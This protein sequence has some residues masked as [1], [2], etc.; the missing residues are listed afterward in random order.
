MPQTLNLSISGM[1]CD[2]CA[3]NVD[4]VLR[5]LP[6]VTDSSTDWRGSSARVIGDGF[7]GVDDVRAAVAGLGFAVTAHRVE[8]GSSDDGADVRHL[9]IIGSGAAAMAAAL[10]AAEAGV[11][12]TLIER[13]RIGGTCVNVGCVP[14]KTLIRAA[15]ALHRA[16]STPFAG[17]EVQGRLRDPAAL[18]R[19]RQDLVDALQQQK[20]VDV[21]ADHPNIRVL[22]GSARFTDARSVRVADTMVRFDRCLIATGSRPALPDIPGLREAQPLDSTAALELESLP[23]SLVILGGRIVALELAQAFARLGVAVTIIQRSGRI[24]PEVDADAAEALTGFLRN[25]GITILTGTR[26]ERVS[27]GPGATSVHLATANGAQVVSGERLL[28]ALGRNA[29]TGDL[30][31]E[32]AGIALAADGS[33]T[34][35]DHLRT[36]NPAVFAAGDVIGDPAFVYAA[37]YEGRVAATNALGGSITRDEAVL[38]WVLFTDPQIA[39]V[40]LGED[41]ARARGI[42]VAVSRLPLDQVP[43]ALAARDTRGFLKLIKEADGDRL[44]GAVFVAPE[45]GDLIQEPTLAIRHGITVPQIIDTFHP[46]LTQIEGVRLAAQG[47]T[48][49]PAKRSC[50]A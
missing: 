18:A 35:D 1:T 33:V 23:L 50:C 45:A 41:A 38:P 12:V 24:L 43:R 28:V 5:T 40:G 46:Y 22:H 19:Q 47:F 20:Y 25:E 11:Q 16:Q 17:L 2:Q 49:D 26:I 30:D 13:G 15:E 7:L 39:V 31:P 8:S 9:A 29:N 32:R 48:L 4:R 3:R 34:V 27:G 14:S 42:P 6:G 44:L 10:H 21:I 37:A 36:S